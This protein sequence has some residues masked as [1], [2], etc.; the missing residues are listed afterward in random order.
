MFGCQIVET[1]A[2]RVPEA[3]HP[4]AEHVL[5]LAPGFLQLARLRFDRVG[6]GMGRVDIGQRPRQAERGRDPVMTAMLQRTPRRK[7]PPTT[8]RPGATGRW[9]GDGRQ[10][11][12]RSDKKSP[13][14]LRAWG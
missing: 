3:P 2:N 1:G 12:R 11:A 5:M 9:A 4:V 8:M 14:P 6:L 7:A 10:A 13:K